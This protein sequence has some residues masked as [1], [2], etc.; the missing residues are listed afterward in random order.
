M[1]ELYQG[2][3]HGRVD[4][5]AARDLLAAQVRVVTAGVPVMFAVDAS[6]LPRPDTRFVADLGRQYAADREGAGGSPTVAGWSMQW[7]AQV[8][9]DPG[10]ASSSWVLPVDVRRVGTAGNANEVAAVQVTDLT[11]GWSP[12]AT[13]WSCSSSMPGTARST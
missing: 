11:L 9:L 12:P 4:E 10:G 5:E 1:G 8:G 13:G 3:E 6:T 7:V 2:L